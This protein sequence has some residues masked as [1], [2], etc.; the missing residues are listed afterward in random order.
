MASLRIT[1]VNLTE[2]WDEYIKHEVA[3][4]AF[5]LQEY[6]MT[7]GPEI[8]GFTALDSVDSFRDRPNI[9]SR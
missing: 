7:E 3:S 2:L 9:S 1:S 6:L 8:L 5:T 4:M